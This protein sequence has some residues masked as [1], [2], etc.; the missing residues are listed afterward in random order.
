MTESKTFAF[1]CVFLKHIS[2]QLGQILK[3]KSVCATS[4]N[5]KSV[6]KSPVS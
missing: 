4:S 2:L 6:F 1:V 5:S 3:Q